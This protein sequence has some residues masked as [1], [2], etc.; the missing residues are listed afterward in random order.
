MIVRELPRDHGHA[1]LLRLDLAHQRLGYIG[2]G[3]EGGGAA[4]IADVDRI[5]DG[6]V[7][8]LDARFRPDDPDDLVEAAFACQIG[9][10][11]CRERVSN[12]V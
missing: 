12:C 1:D 3:G 11:S 7:G 2:V 4:N 8:G 5:G 9:R 6:D 10:A